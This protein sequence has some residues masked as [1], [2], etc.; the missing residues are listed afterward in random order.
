METFVFDPQNLLEI[1]KRNPEE[2]ERIRLREIE[3]LISRAPDHLKPRL[4]GL[5]FQIDCKRKL[6]TNPLGSCIEISKM[7]LDSVAA[8]NDAL[9]GKDTKRPGN[10]C[11]NAEILT[12][13]RIKAHQT[14]QTFSRDKAP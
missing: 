12:F 11:Q 9:H 3:Q 10:N 1:A 13:P 5:Q 7:M 8:L 2:L 4:R 14:N 6:H